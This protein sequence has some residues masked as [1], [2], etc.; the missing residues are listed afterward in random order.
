MPHT[1]TL[2]A[3]VCVGHD[4]DNL[5]S[6]CAYEFWGQKLLVIISQGTMENIRRT[7]FPCKDY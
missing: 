7:I 3:T 4:G 1:K 5:P 6:R 2:S